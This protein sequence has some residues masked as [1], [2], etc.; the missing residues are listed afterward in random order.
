MAFG[1]FG[2][3]AHILRRVAFADLRRRRSLPERLAMLP[4]EAAAVSA[5]LRIS[6]DAH[7]VPFVEAETDD[8][9]AFG[10]GLVHAHLRLG[11]MELMRRLA[12]GRISE[13]VGG[14]GFALD[15]LVRTFD[16]GRAVP[17]I[18]ATMPAETRTWLE[19]FARGINHVVERAPELPLEFSL[20]DLKPEPW[21][22][23]DVVALGRLIAADVNWIV[24]MRLL[25]LRDV[26]PGWPKLWKRLLRHDLSSYAS[27]DKGKHVD[28]L[29][30]TALRSGSNSFVVAGARSQSGAALIANDPHLSIVLPNAWLLAGMKSPSHH[31][32]GMMVPGIPFVAIGRNPWIAWGGA[33]L[34]AASSDLVELPEN[35]PLNE[36]IETIAVRGEAPR[37]LRVR[38][39]QFGPVVSDLPNLRVRD[40]TLALRWMGHRASDEFT[41]M[42]NVGR[43]RNW[44]E[45]RQAF[46]HYDLPGLEMNYADVSG[47]IGQVLAVR[48]PQRPNASPDD[49]FSPPDNGWDNLQGSAELPARYDPPEGFLASANG[50]PW[51][52]K[53]DS[54]IVVSFHFSPGD[55][56]HRLAQL[57]RF[58]STYSTTDLMTIQRDVHLNVRLHKAFLLSWMGT[59]RPRPLSEQE[60]AFYLVIKFWNGNY[61]AGSKGA[62]AFELL[63]FHLARNLIPQSR[64]QAYDAAWGTRTLIWEDIVAAE[65][66][67]RAQALVQAVRQ[68]RRDLARGLEWG[69]IHRLRLIHPLGN[70]P[71]IGR[72]FRFA[73]LP[74]SGTSETLMKTAHGITNR[75]HVAR[76]GSVARHISD[77]A[78]PDANLFALL[79]GQDG[80]FGSTTFADQVELWRRGEYVSVPLQPETARARAAHHTVITPE[81]RS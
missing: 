9:L 28:V 73:D 27:S 70:L 30:G 59:M 21:S 81:P 43:A 47:H 19:S 53:G 5:A 25:K 74:A 13:M 37:T 72:R 52:D 42:L 55:R 51:F 71:L 65:P 78:D 4:S 39:S 76:Y 61:D 15:R 16:I 34:H 46:A 44:Q 40:A 50:R 26:T 1:R 66:S 57:L 62:L 29:A 63:L 69:R 2:I 77:L 36:R 41:A 64:A 18:V 7:Q 35:T 17:D 67:L 45:F 56:T 54:E 79:G 49:I 38:E 48:L 32:V 24:W 23:A 60:R 80:W 20:L 11:Q 31:A 8:D 58:K 68:A 22:I 10:L 75:C 14:F 12:R 6:W 33:S 3:A